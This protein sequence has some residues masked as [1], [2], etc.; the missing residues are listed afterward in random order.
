MSIMDFDKEFAQLV[1]QLPELSACNPA[2]GLSVANLADLTDLLSSVSSLVSKS[3]VR[4][5]CPEASGC[6]PLSSEAVVTLT[7]LYESALS[8][9]DVMC[10]Q[11]EEE[12]EDD[13][14]DE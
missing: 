14:V 3:I 5:L 6:K 7:N 9:F 8:A 12:E 1:T 13:V 2:D 10:V 11:L 4:S